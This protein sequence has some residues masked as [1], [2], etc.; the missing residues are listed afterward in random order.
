M[1]RERGRLNGILKRYTTALIT[2]G[3]EK[4]CTY[5]VPNKKAVT[6]SNS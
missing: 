2:L 1:W 5:V 3:P 4:Y 6:N